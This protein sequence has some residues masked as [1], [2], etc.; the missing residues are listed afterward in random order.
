MS[1][2]YPQQN[3]GA[4]IPDLTGIPTSALQVEYEITLTTNANGLA[5]ILIAPQ[6]YANPIIIMDP[7]STN[8]AITWQAGVA[9][10]YQT[11][12]SGAYSHYRCVSGEIC[13]ISAPVTMTLD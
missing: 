1:L 4:R 11:Q 2:M 13:I 3:I 8:A 7:A 5:G 6:L 12:Y 9:F 10:P